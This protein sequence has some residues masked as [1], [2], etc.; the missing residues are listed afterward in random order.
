MKPYDIDTIINQKRFRTSSS[1]LV[2][3]D[4]YQDDRGC[5]E[6][7]GQ[8]KFLYRTQ[9]GA[10]W[11]VEQLGRG[12]AQCEELDIDGALNAYELLAVK[13]L[14]FGEAFPGVEVQ[15]A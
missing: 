10:Y 6:R 12:R 14:A 15:T 2:A 11:I 13:E 9:R 3:H 7:D 1:T 5:Y 8:N 4:A